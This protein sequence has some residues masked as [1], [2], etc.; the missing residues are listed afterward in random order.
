S[1]PSAPAGGGF[2]EMDDDIPF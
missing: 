1:R 2:D